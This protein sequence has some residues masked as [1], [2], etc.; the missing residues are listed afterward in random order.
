MNR[1]YKSLFLLALAFFC[2]AGVAWSEVDSRL[3]PLI[4]GIDIKETK[5]RYSVQ[6]AIVGVPALLSVCKE[7]LAILGPI[8][9][10]IISDDSVPIHVL[11]NLRAQIA[12]M[13]LQDITC[14]TGKFDHEGH[15]PLV[16]VI[17]QEY[18]EPSL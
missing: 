17:F 18:E 14:V 6:G 4:V 15:G 10:L 5:P 9:V 13:G 12:D 11:M 8:P 1:T 16:K 7:Q 2:L 3:P